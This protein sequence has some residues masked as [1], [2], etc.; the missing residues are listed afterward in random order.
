MKLFHEVQMTNIDK[1]KCLLLNPDSGVD[2]FTDVME[3]MLSYHIVNPVMP[4]G[5]KDLVQHWLK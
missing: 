1:D 2:T 4:Y 5:N 3:K